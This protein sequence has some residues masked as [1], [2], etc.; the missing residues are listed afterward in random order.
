MILQQILFS[1]ARKTNSQQ[2][3]RN[4][5]GPCLIHEQHE[6]HPPRFFSVSVSFRCVSVPWYSVVFVRSSGVLGGYFQGICCFAPIPVQLELVKQYKDSQT[7]SVYVCRMTTSI[8]RRS[9]G[10]CT[11]PA[12]DMPSDVILEGLYK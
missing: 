11:L 4:D 2:C 9:M 10:P 8:F 3:T 5:D 7:R 1:P 12:S 6:K